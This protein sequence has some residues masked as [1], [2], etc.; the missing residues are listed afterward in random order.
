VRPALDEAVD[1]VTDVAQSAAA[2]YER[3]K[4][5]INAVV[6]SA[7]VGLAAYVGCTAMTV[8]TGAIACA[9]VAGAAGGAVYGGM[10]CPE[11][12]SKAQCAAVGA[13][14]GALGGVTAGGLAAAGVGLAGV[15]A[16]SAAASNVADQV[17]RTGEV[18][19]KELLVST[20]AGGALGGLGGALGRAVRGPRTSALA[21]DF[22]PGRAPSTPANGPASASTG[23]AGRW[24]PPS[25]MVR[26]VEEKFGGTATLG[27]PS[28]ARVFVAPA[29]DIAGV[30]SPRALAERLT[31]LDVYGKLRP[32]P[33]SVT[34]FD[35]PAEGL[36]VPVF[37]TNPG[38][39]QGGFTG[40]GAREFDVPNLRY[41]QLGNVQRRIVK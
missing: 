21:D 9:G 14:S 15:G 35:T 7:T 29:E 38:F 5:Q 12:T 2:F 4:T 17:M 30:T 6:A 20:L 34:E 19:P 22:L 13:V 24:E 28:A 33:F 18:D 8:G 16:G 39:V 31:L 11:G 37:R 23:S 1:A 27:H 41:D 26:V 10:T 25:R 36:A 32:G 40:G 3:N